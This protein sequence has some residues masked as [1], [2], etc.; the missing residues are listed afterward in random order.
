MFNTNRSKL[1]AA[2]VAF[3][4]IGSYWAYQKFVTWKNNLKNTVA[5]KVANGKVF[6]MKCI[7]VGATAVAAYCWIDMKMSRRLL[8]D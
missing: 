2:S 1:I 4:G 6:A 8:K 3:G 5:V 7:A